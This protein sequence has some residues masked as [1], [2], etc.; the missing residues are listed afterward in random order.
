MQKVYNNVIDVIITRLRCESSTANAQLR[1]QISILIFW[2][3]SISGGGCICI[4]CTLPLIQYWI[5]LP[6]PPGVWGFDS[7]DSEIVSMWD[8]NLNI[9]NSLQRHRR[10]LRTQYLS[11]SS[12]ET[13]VN[14][15]RIQLNRSTRRQ[16]WVKQLAALWSA[17][18]VE[19]LC[20][21]GLPICFTKQQYC[22]PNG[23]LV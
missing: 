17:T 9:R 6:T 5:R 21:L 3:I 22:R 7:Y 11:N 4:P 18:T 23:A 10:A 2:H 8:F 13:C 15:L 20:V 12:C 1:T 16:I 14:F 19:E